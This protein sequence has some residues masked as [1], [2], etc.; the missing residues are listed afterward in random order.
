MTTDPTSPKRP[1]QEGPD[2][3]RRAGAT[4]ES[5]ILAAMQL[6]A[7]NGFAG[8][9]T[10]AIAARA[11]ANVAAISYHFGS[12][13]GLR[14]ACLAHVAERISGVARAALAGPPP[15]DPA[16]AEALLGRLI[17]ALLTALLSQPQIEHFVAFLLH[18][19][20]QPDPQ[21]DEIYA[22]FLEPMHSRVCDVWALATGN[23]AD[24]AGTRISVFALIG[25]TVYFRLGKPLVQRRLG[26]AQTGPSEIAAIRV[27]LLA[28]LHARIRAERERHER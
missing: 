23:P 24:A 6:F 27:E 12:K 18:E 26:W 25:Q 7:E 2:S 22:E 9:P 14:S 8:T 16:Q 11:G 4:R 15:R 5:L 13:E 20:M 1:D 21:L 19:L 17:D 28:N 10:R 3:G